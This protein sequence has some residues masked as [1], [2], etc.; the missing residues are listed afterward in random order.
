[1]K[2]VLVIASGFPPQGGG[3]V[4]RVHS[5]VKYLPELGWKPVVLTLKE[6]YAFPHAIDASLLNEYDSTVEIFRTRSL[7]PGYSKGNSL[8]S[9]VTGFGSKRSISSTIFRKISQILYKWFL[10]P[11]ERVL[12]IP[13][14]LP[15]G[16]KLVSSKKIDIVFVTTPPHSVSILGYLL[17]KI[18]GVPFVLDIRDDWVGNRYFASQLWHRQKLEKYLE[19]KVISAADAIIVV[20]Q[21]SKNF[22]ETKY[23]SARERIYFIPNG[24]DPED[25]R[26]CTETEAN[27]K[28]CRIVYS[29]SLTRR[30]N[31]HVF[32]EALAELEQQQH[33]SH[34]L[35][36][37]FVGTIHEDNMAVIQNLNLQKIVKFVDHVSHKESIQYLF[38]SD[39]CLLV[40]TSEEGSKTVI[41]SKIYEY[42]GAHKTILALA[43]HDS[44]TARLIREGNIGIVVPSEEKETIKSSLL[45][46][47]ERFHTG[48]LMLEPSPDYLNLFDRS[49]LTG[50]LTDVFNKITQPIEPKPL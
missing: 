10:I 29:G 11:D 33:I 32:F 18:S 48:N 16:K 44:S 5:F 3:G 19:S 4:T 30:R 36:I 14:A 34:Q 50:K 1:M 31:L 40:S 37:L 45:N 12:W 46:I 38:N 17:K 23:P 47:L 21:E 41:P 27:R 42:I 2:Q 39:I 15:K 24:F 13:F 9:R 6:K 28:K 7:E 8:K 43:D 49:C 26:S 22:V 20:T 25:F 35:E